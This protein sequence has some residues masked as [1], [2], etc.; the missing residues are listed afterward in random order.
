MIYQAFTFNVLMM[1]QSWNKILKK[2]LL[3]CLIFLQINVLGQTH[4]I[5]QH[6]DIILHRVTYLLQQLHYNIKDIDDE[7]SN[8]V[9]NNYLES[10]DNPKVIF[11]AEDS[12]MFD[13]YRFTLDDEM[14]GDPVLRYKV[15]NERYQQR[16]KEADSLV[17]VLLKKRFK[18]NKKDSIRLE[19][20]DLR[21]A[22]TRKEWVERWRQLLKYKILVLYNDYLTIDYKDSSM[23]RKTRNMLEVKARNA[24]Q[25]GEKRSIANLLKLTE[26]DEAFQ[27]YINAITNLYDPH[28]AY[29]L[30]IDTRRF[31]E[32]MSGIYY[33][34][35][36]VL[37][38]EM[39]RVSI[40]ELM[41]GGPA[42]K[43]GEIE[44]DDVFVKVQDE[45][46]PEIDVT[47][48]S[49]SELIRLTRGK[50]GSRL[51]ITFRSADQ[52]LKRVTL[53]REAMQLEDTFAKSAI[54]NT[55]GGKIGYITF[56][57]F[58]TSFDEDYGRSCAADVAVE[59]NKL[60]AEG[61]NSIVLD[62]RNNVG[63]SLGEVIDMVGL[64]IEDGPVVQVNSSWNS[65]SI[66]K[67]KPHS[68][69]WDGPLVV[70][71]NEMS[72]SA[73]E[74]FAA[75]I[76]DY[77]RGIVIG[78]RSTFGKGTVQRS[79][80]LNHQLSGYEDIDLG[81]L[82]VTVQKYYRVTGK[83]TQLEGVTS[84][85]I[86]PGLYEPY[87]MQEK[88]NKT[89]LSWDTLAPLSYTVVSGLD[90]VLKD[91]IEQYN[92]DLKNDTTLSAIQKN[93]DWL[94]H[95]SSTVS[96]RLKTYQER[97]QERRN[98]VKF[99]RDRLKTDDQ[100]DVANN[101]MM[102]DH[103]AAAENYKR[104]SNKVWINSLKSDLYLLKAVQLTENLSVKWPNTY[105][106]VN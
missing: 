65:V 15:I 18:F 59:I 11:R 67:M 37:K 98:T 105:Q 9:L 50:K 52:T 32:G 22:M 83:S 68:K 79:V 84:D 10:L 29:F 5:E 94:T 77:R 44:E 14:L 40:R 75:A 12:V 95:Q 99:I 23:N 89:A 33:G 85:I 51:T 91:V 69:I 100:L 92:T 43:S 47:G 28:T 24:I 61:V 16:L 56:P 76:Q 71:V 42:W 35:G 73:S 36:A 80:N 7:F 86:L 78:S 27:N 48:M 30:P 21:F 90:G 70:M 53:I 88:H 82:H 64:F 81:T 39:G 46:D 3:G 49:M 101:Q 1:L 26:P 72:A 45:D 62:I 74:I 58:Y 93:I 13:E 2:G 8:L 31:Q 19:N 106:T 96:L 54:I 60:K 104:E 102:Q 63:G 57:K 25:Q 4:D 97:E 87:E 6:N 103:L 38:E 41:I 17:D 55:I 34:I 66:G 20:N